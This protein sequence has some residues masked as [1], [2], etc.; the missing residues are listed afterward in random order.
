[1]WVCR[2][3]GSGFRVQGKTGSPGLRGFRG[4][5]SA[6]QYCSPSVSL[7]VW[8]LAVRVEGWGCGVR[9][10]GLSVQ[11]VGLGVQGLGFGVLGLSCR[12]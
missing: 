1:M 8:G 5:V 6:S 4:D 3:Q 2:V 12:V 10:A 7:R 11:G 9:G